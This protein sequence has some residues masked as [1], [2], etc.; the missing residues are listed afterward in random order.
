MK[1]CNFQKIKTIMVSLHRGRFVVVHLYSTFS[2]NPPPPK[3]S[4]RG[5][6]IPNI[7]IFRDFGDVGPHF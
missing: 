5:K 6:F 4:H 7:A 2:V 3:F 1:R